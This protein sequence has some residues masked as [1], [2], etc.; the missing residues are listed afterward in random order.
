MAVSAEIRRRAA[1]LRREIVDH[2]H[3]YYILS[4]PVI[5][6]EQYDQLL[7][8]L[9]S[10]E[11]EHPDL[12]TSS[13][14]TQRVGGSIAR[15]FREVSHRTPMLSIESLF[16]RD[17][18]VD[19]D[20]RLRRELQQDQIEYVCELKFD[21]LAINLTYEDGQLLS[22]ALRGNGYAGEDV[23]KNVRHVSTI[24]ARLSGDKMPRVAEIRGEI[25]MRRSTFESF[26]QEGLQVPTRTKWVN[27]RNAVSGQMRQ[28]KPDANV[29]SELLFCAYGVGFLDLVD[30]PTTQHD[31]LKWLTVLGFSVAPERVTV[32]GVDGVLEFHADIE[33]N[34]S[35]FDFD[36][37]GVVAKINSR[38]DQERLGV[39]ARDVKWAAAYKFRAE[40]KPT[41]LRRI[42]LQ[43]GR[44]GVVTPVAR[45]E[46]VFVGQAMVSNATLHNESEILRKGIFANDVVLVRRAGDVI[47]EIVEVYE[48]GPRRDEDRFEMPS[49]CPL[50]NSPLL[51]EEDQKAYRCT[52]VFVCPEQIKG[53]VLHFVSRN[54]M[55]IE[56]VGEGLVESLVTEY[57][58]KDVSD[59]YDIPRLVLSNLKTLE[60]FSPL[61]DHATLGLP[62]SPLW[63]RLFPQS[64][65]PLFSSHIDI[66]A[67]IEVF[68]TKGLADVDVA[69][70]L[71]SLLPKSPLTGS[72]SRRRTRIGEADAYRLFQ[73][74]N[75]SKRPSLSKFLYAM[76]VRLVGEEIA[77]KFAIRFV[78]WEALEAQDWPKLAKKKADL[79][80]E[81]SSRRR[82]GEVLLDDDVAGLGA[83]MLAS[84]G[85]FFLS[86]ERRGIVSRLRSLGVEIQ[87]EEVARPS[88]SRTLFGKTFLFTGTLSGMTR[89]QAADRVMF[90]G[91]AV[92]GSV[93]KRLD[94]LVVGDKPGGKL[95]RANELG[96]KILS[97]AE[98][99]ELTR[100]G[101]GDA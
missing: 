76:G 17:E 12:V 78:T 45:L 1:R 57:G 25:V 11:A 74:I 6:D 7:S 86:P 93:S 21:G 75:D 101:G 16:T 90:L 48:P 56:N 80:K 81:N 37:D 38:P 49:R 28:L 9:K 63:S 36:I 52:G 70:L 41:L 32:T 85:Y 54:A 15:G 72:T 62:K 47:P 35:A 24:P 98:F 99:C 18:V 2:D 51:R 69:V 96:V 34:R 13:S 71:I 83:E 59:L 5:S 92:V 73:Q 95:Q 60:R 33:A 20:T 29:L 44:T 10:I 14:P 64:D 46:P 91:G 26:R 40:T 68:E 23:L 39:S 61:E 4:S 67:A 94:F 30:A 77:K 87:P 89:E 3:R 31:L 79:L 97:E 66:A 88:S 19:F 58:M 55:N 42:D 8:E 22:A 27:P 53:A 50:C 43:I 82:K 100:E 84:I 65:H